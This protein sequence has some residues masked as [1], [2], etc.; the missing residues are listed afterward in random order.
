VNAAAPIVAVCGLAR[1]AAIAAGPGV[2]AIV[3][4][5]NS[6]RLARLLDEAL[7]QGAKGVISFGIAGGVARGLPAGSLVIGEAVVAAEERFPVDLRWRDRLAERL[8]WARVASVAGIERPAADRAAKQSFHAATG[9]VAV[10]MESH[11]AARAAA[12][13]GLPFA[14]LRAVA[15]PA[16]RDLPPAALAPLSPDGTPDLRSILVSLARRPAQLPALV[17]LAFDAR[18]AFATLL[19]SRRALGPGL[20]F[21]DFGDLVLDMA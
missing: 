7:A 5:G 8:P 1:E 10:D 15:D 18:A 20:G 6:Q 12:G 17:G 21:P 13:R 16:E 4:A 11:V 9:V 3:G 19:R 14:L 2:L